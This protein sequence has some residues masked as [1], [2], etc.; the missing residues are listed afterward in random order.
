MGAAMMAF[1]SLLFVFFADRND[2]NAYFS[3]TIAKVFVALVSG[4]IG[5]WIA[6]FFVSS[7][8]S[9][10]LGLII[11]LVVFI[12]LWSAIGWIKSFLITLLTLIA[13]VFIYS[14]AVI[15]AR[16][17]FGDIAHVFSYLDRPEIRL[18]GIMKVVGI[19]LGTWLIMTQL[20]SSLFRSFGQALVATV[21]A[22]GL[23]YF[24]IWI[25]TLGT[26]ASV[27]VF[28]VIYA[29]ILWIMRFRMV[30]NLFAETVRIIRIALIIAVVAGV[31]IW[32]VL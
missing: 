10:V 5:F 8:L 32:I 1:F 7:T 14:F 3:T 9:A 16:A 27:I 15:V 19:I 11:A 6:S 24:L 20:D 12:G 4:V 28:T 23:L 17:F 25:G 22:L 13:F 26:L 31:L 30:S 18:M 2:E 29:V 21:I